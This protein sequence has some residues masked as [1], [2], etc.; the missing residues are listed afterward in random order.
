MFASR[1]IL[2]NSYDGISIVSIINVGFFN[3]SAKT[4]ETTNPE[5][6]INVSSLSE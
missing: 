5:N 1:R 2:L 6:K 3:S 4:G